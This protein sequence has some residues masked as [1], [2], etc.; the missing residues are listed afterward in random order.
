VFRTDHAAGLSTDSE[1]KIKYSS[2]QG[3]TKVA[4]DVPEPDARRFVRV[5]AVKSW[6][7]GK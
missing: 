2:P 4:Q 6:V 5:G 7:M 3:G 1:Y